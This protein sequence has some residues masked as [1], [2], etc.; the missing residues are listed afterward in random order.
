MIIELNAEKEIP[1]MA[2]AEQPQTAPQ[3]TP[4][5]EFETRRRLLRLGAYA[6]PAILG[7]MI[8]GQRSAWASG[9][10]SGKSGGGGHGCNPHGGASCSPSACSPCITKGGKK[11]GS[12]EYNKNSSQCRKY[13]QRY[14]SE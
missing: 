4:S 13:R 11:S 8:M 2:D 3:K 7:M 10:K 6:P 12:Y 9:D 1:A 5:N 14:W